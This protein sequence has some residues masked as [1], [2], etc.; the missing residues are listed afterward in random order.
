MPESGRVHVSS[1]PLIQHKLTVLRDVNT[2][3]KEFREVIR[4]ITMLLAY[5][6]TQDMA[7]RDVR[8]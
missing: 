8:V 1:H 6:A 5:E 2:E 4:E 3:P 7:L